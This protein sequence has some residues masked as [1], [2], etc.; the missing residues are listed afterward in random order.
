MSKVLQNVSATSL[1]DISNLLIA[2]FTKILTNVGPNTRPLTDKF[3]SSLSNPATHATP[4]NP[5]SMFILAFVRLCLCT[6]V[7]D[8]DLQSC[9]SH[10]A[11][12]MLYIDPSASDPTE[13][14]VL[15]LT[16]LA[17]QLASSTRRDVNMCHL[18]C[19]T[20]FREIGNE[21]SIRVPRM[22]KSHAWQQYDKQ[23]Q[24]Y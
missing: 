14:T 5:T 6:Q 13:C 21:A 20:P 19:H 15:V 12:C 2:S 22:F 11:S 10:S 18:S 16:S 3:Y 24:C 4:R 7:P 1:R 23:M 8:T 17:L 9:A